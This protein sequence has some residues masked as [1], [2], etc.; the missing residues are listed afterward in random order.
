MF[1]SQ[2]LRHFFSNFTQHIENIDFSEKMKPSV[3][4]PFFLFYFFPV[5]TPARS[6]SF[7]VLWGQ[8]GFPMVKWSHVKFEKLKLEKHFCRM[9]DNPIPRNSFLPP[10]QQLDGKHQ[11]IKILLTL[12]S[13][14]IS[15][16]LLL[17][18]SWPLKFFQPWITCLRAFLHIE[19][20]PAS[21]NSIMRR[22]KHY[23]EVYS[24]LCQT[25]KT[26]LFAKIVHALCPLKIFWGGIY[27]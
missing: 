4:F 17:S 23:V 18:R 26:E 22:R 11:N 12:P 19:Q 24:E 2:S 8:S 27:Q 1:K 3:T 20:P 5:I 15:S 25:S 7:V 10:S 13:S 6:T 9:R 14:F 16:M 21:L